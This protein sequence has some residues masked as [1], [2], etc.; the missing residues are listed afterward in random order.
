MKLDV[1]DGMDEIRVCTG[2]TVAGKAV[3]LLPTGADAVAECVAVYESLPGWT[4]STVGVRSFDALPANARAY[5]RRVEALAGV[6][7]AMVSTGP[8]RDDTILL[9]HPFR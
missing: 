2:Y 8:E 3:E 7:L 4:D 6:P 1:L 5:L 9:H